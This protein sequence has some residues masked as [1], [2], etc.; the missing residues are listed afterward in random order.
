MKV[1]VTDYVLLRY[2]PMARTLGDLTFFLKSYFSVKP[3]TYDHHVNPIPWR[4]DE[5][6]S[7]K[8]GKLRWAV[9]RDD[10]TFKHE[11]LS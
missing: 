5:Y 6:K 9:M 2:S 3:W 10:G 8:E 11:T 4:E 1:F 7:G